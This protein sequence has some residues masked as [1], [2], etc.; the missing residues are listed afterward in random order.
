MA[1]KKAKKKLDVGSALTALLKKGCTSEQYAEAAGIEVST[2]R[3]RLKESML[4]NEVV[5]YVPP[6]SKDE[7]RVRASTK[8][9][10][11]GAASR[12]RR[13]PHYKLA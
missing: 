5:R 4:A 10:T 13:K 8:L 1:P 12:T 9:L 6:L 3:L 7:K 2:A 11:V